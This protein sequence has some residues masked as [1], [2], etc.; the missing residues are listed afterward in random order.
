[1]FDWEC[2]IPGICITLTCTPITTYSYSTNQKI[3]RS[4]SSRPIQKIREVVVSRTISSFTV[5]VTVTTIACTGREDSRSRVEEITAEAILNYFKTSS[6][7]TV[8]LYENPTCNES[9]KR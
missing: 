9:K 7:Y 3:R 2:I 1:M 8:A 5:P 6:V 4:R